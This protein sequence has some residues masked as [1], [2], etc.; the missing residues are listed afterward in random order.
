MRALDVRMGSGVESLTRQELSAFPVE[1]DGDVRLIDR[2]K[3]IWNPQ[4]FEATLTILSSPDGPYADEQI[5][6]GIWSYHYRTGS[7][8]GD[9]RKLRRAWELQLPLI[10]WRKIDKGVFVPLYPVF[11]TGDDPEARLFTISLDEVRFLGDPGAFTDDSRRYAQQIVRRRLHQPEF[12]GRVLRAYDR[13]C[14][15]CKLETPQLLDA[16]HILPDSHVMGEAI[17]RNGL[18]LCKIHHAAYDANLLGISP[19][20]VVH[21]NRELLDIADGP[22][23]QHGLKDMHLQRLLWSPRK[24]NDR[25]DTQRLDIRF[26]EFKNAS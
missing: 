9:N 1:G 8:D 22:M 24:P 19:D 18:A 2:S 4:A 5:A 23:L 25:P 20:N 15:V 12:R 10:M 13:H 14:T 11:V 16:A 21:I 6:P 26:Q 17:V 3:G 7:I